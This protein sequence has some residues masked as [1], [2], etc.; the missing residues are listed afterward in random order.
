MT[1]VY[2]DVC[3]LNRPFDDQSQGRVKLETT[4]VKAI[5]ERIRAGLYAGIGSEAVRLETNRIS[6]PERKTYV[7]AQERLFTQI[8]VIRPE[9]TQ[10]GVLLQAMGFG[11]LDALHIACAESAE[12][13]VLLTTDD[14]ML[15]LA[16]RVSQKLFVKVANPA[17]WL[18]EIENHET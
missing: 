12:A 5:I 11:T 18:M 16:A 6:D 17:V 7:Q 1:K 14:R 15:R 13:D 4:A 10:R 3:C 9:L 2:L 8:I